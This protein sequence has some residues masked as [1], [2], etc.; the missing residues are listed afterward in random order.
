MNEEQR[1]TALEEG[2]LSINALLTAMV[3]Q[4]K[5]DSQPKVEMQ[6]VQQP[7]VVVP[8][9]PAVFSEAE[10]RNLAI[11]KDGEEPTKR[12]VVPALKGAKLLAFVNQYATAELLHF[13]E[14]RGLIRV[15]KA[16]L[17]KASGSTAKA[18]QNRSLLVEQG[19]GGGFKA[20]GS[21]SK[22]SSY[23]LTLSSA[24]ERGLTFVKDE[25]GDFRP[26]VCEP[27]AAQPKA[28]QGAT[29]GCFSAAY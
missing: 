6:P 13:D 1:L 26:M 11:R 22:A 3:G 5:V 16:K 14:P 17:T 18:R 28:E 27:R 19:F 10:S 25:G 7:V 4:P 9:D 8:R 21:R 29:E 20:D 12:N 15:P 2:I 23:Y 24:E